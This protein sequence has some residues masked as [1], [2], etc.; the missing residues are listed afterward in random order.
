MWNFIKNRISNKSASLKKEMRDIVTITEIFKKFEQHGLV[1]WRLKDKVL[2]IEE[3]LA[4]VNMTGGREAFQKFLDQAAMWQNARLISD[5]YEAY[6]IK[7]ETD[8]VRQAEKN[9]SVLTKADIARI[10]QH[11]RREMRMLP[12]EELDY[13]KEFDIFIIR[14]HA[15][16]A[17][18]ADPMSNELLAVGHYD[19]KKVE[20]ALYKEIKH[21]LIK[22]DKDD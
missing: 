2:L 22:T 15:P 12:L 10:R 8:A 13:I 18:N 5:G 9:F 11:A 20:M 6:R 17:Q 21:N 7:V 4:L 14:S 19:G 3:S 1:S 16:S